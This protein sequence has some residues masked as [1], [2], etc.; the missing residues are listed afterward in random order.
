[1]TSLDEKNDILDKTVFVL[2]GDPEAILDKHLNRLT[3]DL[4]LKILKE[5]QKDKDKTQ[6]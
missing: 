3:Y 6:I 5:S 4:S 1:V 2:K